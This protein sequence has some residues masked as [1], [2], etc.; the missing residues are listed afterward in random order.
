MRRIHIGYAFASLLPILAIPVD[1]S[2][3]SAGGAAEPSPASSAE[4]GAG[5][6]ILAVILLLI[7]AIGVAVKLYDV[8]RK[9]TE[10]N[11]GLQ[12]LLSEALMLEPSFGGLPV[13]AFVSQSVWPR[14]PV[15]IDVRGSVPTS[16]LRDAA[17]RLVER[18]AS[19]RRPGARIE[20]RLLVDP[21][22]VQERAPSS[23]R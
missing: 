12:S 7:I 6:G 16:E 23:M 19:H 22:I 4:W 10:V 9:R 11:A 8:K 5:I 1:G 15:V 3:Q 2:A 20:D 21:Q 14:S 18:E 13:T 17:M